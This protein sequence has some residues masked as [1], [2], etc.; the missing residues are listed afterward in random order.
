MDY[1]YSVYRNH[2]EWISQAHKLGIPVVAWTM[3][4]QPQLIEMANAEADILATDWPLL[5]F[6]IRNY[7]LRHQSE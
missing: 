4:T 2:P 5:G 3:N 6:Q 1:S 7:Y